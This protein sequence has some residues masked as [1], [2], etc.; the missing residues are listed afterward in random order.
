MDII[1]VVVVGGAHSGISTAYELI[2]AGAKEV[3]VL[4]AGKV[5]RGSDDFFAGTGSVQKIPTAKMLTTTLEPN[6]KTFIKKNN[7]NYET[8]KICYE[9]AK[10]GVKLQVAR[11]KSYQ[12]DLVKEYG[13]IAIATDE[14]NMAKLLDEQRQYLQID[15]ESKI[16]SVSSSEIEKYFNQHKFFGGIYY[17]EDAILNAEGYLAALINETKLDVIEDTRVVKITEK[18]SYVEI[19]TAERGVVYA[20][21]V[22]LATNGFKNIINLPQLT[23]RWCFEISMDSSG[24]DTPN[25]FTAGDEYFFFSRQ[26]GQLLVG[27]VDLPANTEPGVRV[28]I[29]EQPSIQKIKEWAQENFTGIGRVTDQ[30]WGIFGQTENNFP[31]AGLV[32]GTERTYFIGGCN[33]NGQ[34]LLAYAANLMPAVMGYRAAYVNE[35]SAIKI[36]AIQDQA[37]VQQSYKVA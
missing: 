21:Q 33:G 20:K 14:T 17:P 3:L 28:A 15:P 26:N 9:I 11:A 4:E 2:A 12:L 37:A 13:S 8:A 5:A 30:H 19:E 7:Y 16:S 25:F 35:Y 18:E 34:P 10:R 23:G 6:I 36:F 29:D 22:V 24:V 31:M 27:G 1:E 32:P